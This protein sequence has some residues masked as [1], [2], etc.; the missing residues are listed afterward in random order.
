MVLEK[1]LDPNYI[2]YCHYCC[3]RMQILNLLLLLLFFKKGPESTHL[4]PSICSTNFVSTE[5][6]KQLEIIN[7]SP[8]LN[9]ALF[10]VTPLLRNVT[11]SWKVR[12]NKEFKN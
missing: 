11:L 2:R 6:S 12:K 5:A 3:K 8:V 7:L 9:V 1:A 4:F 10:F